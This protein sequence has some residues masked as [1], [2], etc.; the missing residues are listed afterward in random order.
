MKWASARGHCTDYSAWR[1]I[2]LTM[3]VTA[4]IAFAIVLLIALF[5]LCLAPRNATAGDIVNFRTAR[6]L[7]PATI[8]LDKVVSRV[9]SP[10]AEIYMEV[11]AYTASV[12]ET[13]ATP[14]ITASG[15]RV[16]VGGVAADL[17]K[18]PLGTILRIPSYNGGKPCTVIDSGGSIRGNKLDVFMWSTHEAVHFGRR[19]NVK[20]QVLYRPKA[21]Q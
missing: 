19:R 4:I 18:F 10:I 13:D 5:V 12:A 20:V 14:L 9:S 2:G 6:R 1:D 17:R 11:S 7:A 8:H 3:L 16:Y 21:K 15:K